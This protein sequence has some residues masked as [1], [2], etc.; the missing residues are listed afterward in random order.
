M[1]S[2][3]DQAAQV[4][5]EIDAELAICDKATAG[6][7]RAIAGDSYCAY[8]T[9]IKDKGPHFILF[10]VNDVEK[11]TAEADT[12]FPGMDIDATFIASARTVCPKS[13]RC[14][15]TAIEGWLKLTTRPPGDTPDEV[16]HT[17]DG[18]ADDAEEILTT[19][20]T[21]WNSK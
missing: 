1:N 10:D 4:I 5:A 19:L 2:L 6:P 14:L 16:C 11:E 17:I 8:P 15:K 3:T 9:V 20:I 12:R 13:L 21:Q 18:Y 7:W